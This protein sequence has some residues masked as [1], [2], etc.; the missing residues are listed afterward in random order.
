MRKRK[1]K[2]DHRRPNP[3]M[4]R[5]LKR[6]VQGGR[7]Q[8]GF[9]IEVCKRKG[10]SFHMYMKGQGAEPQGFKKNRNEVCNQERKN[11]LTNSLVEQKK[12]WQRP[13]CL[14]KGG[15]TEKNDK[16]RPPREGGVSRSAVSPGIKERE[17]CRGKVETLSVKKD[18]GQERQKRTEGGCLFQQRWGGGGGGYQRKLPEKGKKKK[19]LNGTGQGGEGKFVLPG[20]RNPP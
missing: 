1:G 19:S 18:R 2:R 3:E 8:G 17:V 9:E 15:S 10:G 16:K 11:G 20:S 13:T 7:L 5:K 12:G 14:D 4:Q 6:K